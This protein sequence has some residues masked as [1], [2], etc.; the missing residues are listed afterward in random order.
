MSNTDF[1]VIKAVQTKRH[2]RCYKKRSRGRKQGGK[3]HIRLRKKKTLDIL[4]I[5][6][7]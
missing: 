7:V 1:G 5:E 3:I 4:R 2:L 6:E